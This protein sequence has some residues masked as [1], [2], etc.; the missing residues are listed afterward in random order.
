MHTGSRIGAS[1]TLGVRV[2]RKHKPGTLLGYIWAYD[3][4]TVC[5]SSTSK[6]EGTRDDGIQILVLFELGDP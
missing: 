3:D 5:R 6:W 4:G 2:I 1:G